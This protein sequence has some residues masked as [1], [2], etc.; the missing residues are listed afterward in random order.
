MRSWSAHSTRIVFS[1]RFDGN[2]EFFVMNA[3]GGG[4]TG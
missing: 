4:Q 1:Q 3:D 2:P